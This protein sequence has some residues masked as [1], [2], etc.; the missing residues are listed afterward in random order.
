M[1]KK[2]K[3]IFTAQ[4]IY[5]ARKALKKAEKKRK[6]TKQIYPFGFE[7]KKERE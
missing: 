6:Q 1:K 3:R 5:S 2:K 7:Y 4:E